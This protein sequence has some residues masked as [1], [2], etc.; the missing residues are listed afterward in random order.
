MKIE[1]PKNN[2]LKKNQLEL[3]LLDIKKAKG[4]PNEYYTEDACLKVEQEKIFN[5]GWFAIGFINDLDQPGSVI[6]VTYFNNPMLIVRSKEDNKVRVFQNVCRHRGMKLIDEPTVLKGAIRCRY[7]SWCYKQTGENC[8]TPHIGGPGIN[9]HE[10]IDK[11]ELNLFEV[12]THIWRGVVF[13]NPDGNAPKFEDMHASIIKRWEIFDQELYT[14]QTESSFK[15]ELNSNWKLAVENYLEA[16]HLPWVHP[17]LNSYSKLEDHENIVNYGNY[18]GQISYKYNPI[19]STGKKFK[20]FK[21]LGSEWNSK[22]EYI[23]LFPNLI[24]GVQRDHTF[25]Q[26]IEPVSSEKIIEHT[27]IYYSDPKM[28]D[29]KYQSTRLEN[30]HLWKTVFEE[31]IFVVEGMHKGRYAKH[32]DGGFFSPIMDLPTHVFHDWYARKILQY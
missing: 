13:V 25:N 18:S 15:L 17:G 19:F 16:Y 29:Q 23:V 14:D 3:C 11:N 6:P 8:A 31:D 9:F 7:H 24:M 30:A 26:I 28:L 2:I 5:N 32:F 1:I 10:S 20:D 22:G 4:I 12:R 21:N 27:Q